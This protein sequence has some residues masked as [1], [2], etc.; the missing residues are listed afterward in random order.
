[1]IKAEKYE[2]AVAKMANRNLMSV[3]GITFVDPD[4]R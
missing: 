1:M 3:L 2:I 4:W